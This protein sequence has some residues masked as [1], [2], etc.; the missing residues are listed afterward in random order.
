MAIRR[1]VN[2]AHLL[3]GTHAENMGDMARRDRAAKGERSGCAKFTDADVAAMRALRDQGV[4]T[5]DIAQRFG[6]SQSYASRLMRGE[7]RAS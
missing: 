4:R 3:L 1:C 6:V 2:P 7:R 5:V